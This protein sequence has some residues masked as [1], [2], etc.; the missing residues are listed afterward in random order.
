MNTT[1]CARISVA[2]STIVVVMAVSFVL[3]FLLL[4]RQN[5]QTV[6]VMAHN[7]HQFF[8]DQYGGIPTDVTAG[9]NSF[10]TSGEPERHMG[11]IKLTADGH[12]MRIKPLYQIDQLKASAPEKAE[13]LQDV[14][15][16]LSIQA[17]TRT[18]SLKNPKA[19]PL[20][21]R[22]KCKRSLT[23]NSGQKNGCAVS[24]GVAGQLSHS[25]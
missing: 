7:R 8:P 16:P 22:R 4:P 10:F 23:W 11:P 21:F 18:F 3:T 12:A 25:I 13:F 20:L 19:S 5:D 2:A 1:T 9:N 15:I 14:V 6:R 24:N 17:L